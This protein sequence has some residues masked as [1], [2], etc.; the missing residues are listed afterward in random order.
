MPQIK[1]PDYNGGFI[2]KSIE[3]QRII[4]RDARGYKLDDQPINYIRKGI[5]TKFGKVIDFNNDTVTLRR[6]GEIKTADRFKFNAFLAKSFNTK[7]I[8][9]TDKLKV[10]GTLTTP[11]YNVEVS[12]EPNIVRGILT[13]PDAIVNKDK[14]DIF[15]KQLGNKIFRVEV[16]KPLFGKKGVFKSFSY[17]DIR[18]EVKRRKK[19]L[20]KGKETTA[21]ISP[22]K[23]TQPS[24]V[25]WNVKGGQK[26]GH[27]YIERRPHPSGEGYIYLYELPTGK[28]EWRDEAGQTVKTPGMPQQYEIPELKKGD[29]IK[30]GD[31]L[32]KVDDVSDNLIAVN[33]KGKLKIINKKEHLEK[34]NAHQLYKPGMEI[35]YN[36]SP[37]EIIQKTDNLALIKDKETNKLIV[38]HLERHLQKQQGGKFQEKKINKYS[39][40]YQGYAE[41]D[42]LYEIDYE[43]QP[44]YQQFIEAS[45]KAGLGTEDPLK[46]KK[47]LKVGDKVRTVTWRYNP[48]TRR[49]EYLTDGVK[50]HPLYFMDKKFKIRDITPEGYSLESSEGETGLFLSH[51]DYENYKPEEPEEEVVMEKTGDSVGSTIVKVPKK[52]LHISGEIPPERLEKIER[53]KARVKTSKYLSRWT[54]KNQ[55][56]Q[57]EEDKAKAQA[58][59]EANQEKL[60]EFLQSDEYKGFEKQAKER[61]FEF[62]D[63]KLNATKKVDIE[64]RKF[65]V[66]TELKTD[67]TVNTNVDG[68]VKKLKLGDGNYKITD[69]TKDKVFYDED[70]EEKEISFDDLRSINGKALFEPTKES[71]GLV[72]KLEPQKFYFGTGDKDSASGYYEIVDAKDLVASHLPGGE[73]NKHYSI[74]DAQNRDRSTPQSLAQINKI[75]TNPNFD[76]LS[77][78]RTA[79][80]GAPI[81]NQD[82]NIIAGNGRGIGIQQHYQ[83]GGDKYKQDLLNNAEKLGFSK[84]EISK[85]EQPVLIRRINVDN[86]EA[87]RLGAISNTSQMLATEEREQAKGK[88]TR[89]DDKTFN[90]ISDIFKQAKGDYTSISDYL[91]DIGPKLVNELQSKGIIPENEAHLYFNTATGKLDASHKNKVKELLTQSILGDSSQHFEK[92][93]DA[94][95]EGIT[96]GLGEIFA[97]KGQSGDLVP[98]L[99]NAIKILAKYNAVKDSFGNTD[100]FLKQAQND[101]FEPLKANKEELA[102]FEL[103]TSKSPNEIKN[104]I[105][106]YS[107]LMESDMFSEGM[108]PEEAFDK[109]FTPKYPKGINKG[110][111][112]TLRLFGRKL[113]KSQLGLFTGQEK[114]GKKLLP[115]KKNP[116]VRR[117]QTVEEANQYIEEKSKEYGGKNKFLASDEYREAYPE[118]Q[119]L[120]QEAKE[121]FGSKAQEALR[122]AGQK[123]GDQVEFSQANPFG[124]VFVFEGKI[125]LKDGVPYV[126]LDKKTEDGKSAVKWH[127]GFR[128]MDNGK[129][130]MASDGIRVYR[131]MRSPVESEG[132]YVAGKFVTTSK[133]NAER[134]ARGEVPVE[135][136][137]I[138]NGLTLLE[139]DSKE[140]DELVSELLYS[141]GDEGGGKDKGEPIDQDDKDLLFFGEAEETWV[142]FLR[143][144]GY[145]GT[146]YN[147][148]YGTKSDPAIEYHI[149]DKSIIKK[150][151][152]KAFGKEIKRAESDGPMTYKKAVEKNLN[153]MGTPRDEW[154]ALDII[155]HQQMANDK[156]VMVE[157]PLFDFESIKGY[158]T[159]N[160]LYK[161]HG[162]GSEATC[163]LCG[164]TPIKHIYWIKNDKKKYVLAVGSECVKHFS[165]K[166]GEELSRDVKLNYAKEVFEQLYENAPL[167]KRLFYWDNKRSAGYGKNHYSWTNDE[168]RK[169]YHQIND[170]GLTEDMFNSKRQEELRISDKD[171]EKNILTK[172]TLVKKK[173]IDLDKLVRESTKLISDNPDK[174]AKKLHEGQKYNKWNSYY[175]G[176]IKPVVSKTRELAKAEGLSKEEARVAEISA[177]LHDALEDTGVSSGMI[178]RFYGPEVE[179]VV[180]LL[181]KKIKSENIRIEPEE[182]YGKIGNDKIARVVKAADRIMNIEKSGKKEPYILKEE[183]ELRERM[184]REYNADMDYIRRHNIYPDLIGQALTEA[185]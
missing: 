48:E 79:Q 141:L 147:N 181:S 156:G 115:S 7:P 86:K 59:Y 184:L 88:A 62:G 13:F 160:T 117:W 155:G 64:G 55:P 32:G 28:R 33:F 37:A 60:K 177:Y 111:I 94:A 168:I 138:P 139:Y 125:F 146:S 171:N 142:N 12:N 153:Q 183:K 4:T 158:K 24:G 18:S 21:T 105:K 91:E 95:R 2:T 34:V 122:E 123:V 173:G 49:M 106:E 172:L 162:V 75:A 124:Q 67:G 182:Y 68:P 87:Q 81:V 145:D 98:H 42:H 6:N 77:D 99:Q 143:G 39:K 129:G 157:M 169:M 101:V 78:N 108:K 118:I 166:S 29:L 50:D 1:I 46:R 150:P 104:K 72:S 54:K 131:A 44:E 43:N 58:E 149:F 103:L 83:Q 128:K 57:S 74:S 134:Y 113:L 93:P 130:K 63:N 22:G 107:Q 40:V 165:P 114:D 97:K 109:A 180:R 164:K 5:N 56:I 133:R 17:E 126:K 9:I 179:R 89:I 80:D 121:N 61:G 174:L 176:H 41:E 167:L 148:S 110:L 25:N 11:I 45:E 96:K 15:V 38:I 69:I 132:G 163:E 27:K 119:K 85:M 19:Y 178:R 154:N 144:K 14:N 90:K 84:D 71:K 35:S 140:A 152:P 26:P 136:F 23:T 20:F 135:E 175:E 82:Y 159:P 100:A 16:K 102:M 30:Q 73:A 31:L 8:T 51:E 185:V 137:V 161:N 116:G 120:H 10:S 70:G 36:G 52:T 151:Q 66:R 53:E 112:N 76:F 92:I 3:G 127:K 65:E 170:I 47:Y